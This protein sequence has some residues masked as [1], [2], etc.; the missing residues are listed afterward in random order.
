M[1]EITIDAE[2]ARAV[3]D[4]EESLSA[5]FMPFNLLS[6]DRVRIITILDLVKSNEDGK[7]Y[8]KR[9]YGEL[10]SSSRFNFEGRVG[11]GI[12]LLM[13]FVDA[14]PMD[15][16]QALVPF[17]FLYGRCRGFATLMGRVVGGGMQAVGLW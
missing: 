8:I 4:L 11:R 13:G 7:F 3:I 5:S 2:N 12:F 9:Q 10:P 16:F 6:V 1:V 17:R 14:V 15:S